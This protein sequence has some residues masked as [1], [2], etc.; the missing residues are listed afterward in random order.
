MARPRLDIV[1]VWICWIFGYVDVKLEVEKGMKV[2]VF[3]SMDMLIAPQV[4]GHIYELLA[5]VHMNNSATENH[6]P[7]PVYIPASWAARPPIFQSQRSRAYDLPN[8]RPPH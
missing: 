7:E 4:E 2:N 1:D 3:K 8:P 6:F 5:I